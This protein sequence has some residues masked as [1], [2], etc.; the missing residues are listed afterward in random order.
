MNGKGMTPSKNYNLNLYWENYDSIFR[1]PKCEKLD[2]IAKE[3]LADELDR[4]SY[5]EIQKTCCGG[6]CCEKTLE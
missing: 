5:S 6:N 4:T 2:D 3:E 1:K